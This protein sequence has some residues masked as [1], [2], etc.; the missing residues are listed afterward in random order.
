MNRPYLLAGVA[1]H[2]SNTFM[3]LR[4][5]LFR[6]LAKICAEGSAEAT[7]TGD[8]TYVD[9]VHLPAVAAVGRIDHHASPVGAE[10]R[11]RI[12][13]PFACVL[14]RRMEMAQ[15]NPFA[16]RHIIKIDVLVSRLV[17]IGIVENPPIARQVGAMPVAC[18][19]TLTDD[20]N[21]RRAVLVEIERVAVGGVPQAQARI[22]LGSRQ[23]KW[24]V[25][26]CGSTT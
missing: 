16:G 23:I 20:L 3:L 13:A 5:L 19:H 25:W 10:S 9:E 12:T 15:R 2:K 14:R 22:C 24:E 8:S 1:G 17:W 4:T 7:S 11:V 6:W 18:H 26:P 21:L